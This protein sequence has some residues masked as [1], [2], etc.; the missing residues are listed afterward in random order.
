VIVSCSDLCGA[1]QEERRITERQKKERDLSDRLTYPPQTNKD[2]GKKGL[3]KPSFCCC[4]F[5]LHQVFVRLS[6]ISS[7]LPVYSQPHIS[8]YL[9]LNSLSSNVN[10]Q[11]SVPSIATRL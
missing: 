7:N 11:K 2:Y 5:L 1:Q 6:F 4:C 3:F 8:P 9:Q 10:N